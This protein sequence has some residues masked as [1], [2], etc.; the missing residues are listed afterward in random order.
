MDERLQKTLQAFYEITHC[1]IA[2][3]DEWRN[4]IIAYPKKLCD[5]CRCLREN[6]IADAR[7]RACDDAAFLRTKQSDTL[8][9]YACH[10]GLTE[11]IAPVRNEN[12]VFLGYIM[13]G[14]ATTEN[15]RL[16]IE[17]TAAQYMEKERASLLLH[18]VPLLQRQVIES[19]SYLMT[20]CAEYLCLTKSIQKKYTPLVQKITKF[21]LDNLQSKL[22]LLQLSQQF[23]MSESSLYFLTKK[24]YNLPP[25]EYINSLRLEKAR[26]LISKTDLKLNEIGE[27]V[28]ICDGNY[29]G[30]LLRKKYGKSYREIKKETLQN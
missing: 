24:Y 18:S 8:E 12:G 21:I 11:C 9:I 7:C 23:H 13:I 15:E 28:G 6:K 4:E 25:I 22:T 5:F 16:S 19:S 14:Q 1:R 2:I 27:L 20:V 3:F 10:M 30:R 26:A 17:C 29:L